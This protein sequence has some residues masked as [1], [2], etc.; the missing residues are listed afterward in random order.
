MLLRRFT[1]IAPVNKPVV[2]VASIL[3]VSNIIVVPQDPDSVFDGVD[4]KNIFQCMFYY[5]HISRFSEVRG[6]KVRL[7]D[8]F[9][10][11]RENRHLAWICVEFSRLVFS[12]LSKDVEMKIMSRSYNQELVVRLYTREIE[13]IRRMGSVYEEYETPSKD[14]RITAVNQEY[15]NRHVEMCRYQE[16][17]FKEI[18]INDLLTLYSKF[19]IDLDQLTRPVFQDSYES[20]TPKNDL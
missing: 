6:I 20:P 10:K 12:K 13:V 3:D 19:V 11:I 17:N 8:A 15:Y 5:P 1:C 2:Q 16:E 4:E 9:F 7:Q 14:P 18:C